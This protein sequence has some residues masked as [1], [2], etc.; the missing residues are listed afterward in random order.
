MGGIIIRLNGDPSGIRKLSNR[1]LKHISE[2]DLDDY[3]HDFTYE[4]IGS[5]K[6]L[7]SFAFMVLN[8]NCL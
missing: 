2:I 7:E 6:D 8:V 3:E 5:I 4:N 1:D